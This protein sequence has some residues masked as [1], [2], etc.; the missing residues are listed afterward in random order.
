MVVIPMA[1]PASPGRS[2]EST[3]VPGDRSDRYT[4]KSVTCPMK[5]RRGNSTARLT[6]SESR[7]WKEIA[8]RQAEF[9][10]PTRNVSESRY[11]PLVSRRAA[12]HPWCSRH[13]ASTSQRRRDKDSGRYSAAIRANQ[14]H[15]AGPRRDGENQGLS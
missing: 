12:D 4:V 7:C 10:Y 5:A 1:M 15:L 8:Y 6:S 14:H 13:I 9:V 3:I 2:W 11:G